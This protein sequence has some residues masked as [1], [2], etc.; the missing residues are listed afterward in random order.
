M[1]D[2]EVFDPSSAT[3]RTPIT[4]LPDYGRFV[5]LMPP[6]VG[7]GAANVRVRFRDIDGAALSTVV[8][9]GF[10]VGSQSIVPF[11]DPTLS[12][13]VTLIR[14]V[15]ITELRTRIDAVR[16]RFALGAFGYTDPGPVSG[17]MVKAVHIQ[18][19]RTALDQAYRR[20]A[21]N[22]AKLQREPGG[23]HGGRRG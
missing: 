22:A 3:Y 11:T 4:R 17:V 7:D 9:P 12:P 8:T 15:H 14:A 13:G 16:A 20:G 6:N 2:L 21:T 18:Q 23:G 5:L 1:V 10:T 19:L